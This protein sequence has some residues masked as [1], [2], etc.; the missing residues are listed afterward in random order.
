MFIPTVSGKLY[1]ALDTLSPSLCSPSYTIGRQ[2]RQALLDIDVP[3]GWSK[4]DSQ[5][6]SVSFRQDKRKGDS[7]KIHW[8]GGIEIQVDRWVDNKVVSTRRPVK[9][10]QVALV[11]QTTLDML[12]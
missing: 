9:L 2:I 11:C 8:A 4:L 3:V 12:C 7:V 1:H 10:A 5:G 6:A